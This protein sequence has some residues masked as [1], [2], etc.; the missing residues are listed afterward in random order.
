[1]PVRYPR[2]PL[3]R[4]LV[5]PPEFSAIQRDCCMTMTTGPYLWNRGHTFAVLAALFTYLY[6]RKIAD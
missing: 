3:A 4:L 6:L 1:L 2:E 5:E